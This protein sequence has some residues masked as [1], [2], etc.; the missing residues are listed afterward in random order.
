[1]Q[2]SMRQKLL[3]FLVAVTLVAPPLHAAKECTLQQYAELPITISESRPFIS[4][5]IN[6]QPVRFLV[7]NT[8][9]Y[10]IL[11]L[12]NALKWHLKTNPRP[13]EITANRASGW[14]NAGIT[15]VREF[16]LAGLGGGRVTKDADFWVVAHTFTP[17]FVGLIGR[18]IIGF[19]DT[20]YD[21]AR[22]V[23]R[24]FYSEHC[25]GDTLAYWRGTANV[26]E[27]TL[28]KTTTLSSTL[29]G[30]A[31]INDKKVRVLFSTGASHSILSP[32]AARRV[33]VRPEDDTVVATGKI[34]PIGEATTNA[35]IARV[36]SLNLG[37]EALKDV[38][39]LVGDI[40]DIPFVDL[41]L[42]ADFFLA[43]RVYV[44]SKPRKIYFTYNGGSIFNLTEANVDR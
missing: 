3:G 10:S 2:L 35:R 30:T 39:V 25:G 28:E 32:K 43:H 17:D 14:E 22:G 34:F 7:D 44:G 20:E 12:D 41:V 21:L 38:R 6:G 33:G 13:S 29:T 24:L 18:D 8:A 31:A 11:S 40:K 42:G 26:A 15:T 9:P 5:T 27:I 19:A 4:G 16:S 37:G 36:D 1:M 23:I